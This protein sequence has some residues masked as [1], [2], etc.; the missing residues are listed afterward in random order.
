MAENRI[1]PTAHDPEVGR[2]D[3]CRVHVFAK[4]NHYGGVGRNASRAVDAVCEND[5]RRCCVRH[6]VH[7][8]RVTSGVSSTVGRCDGNRVNSS[9]KWYRISIP[10]HVNLDQAAWEEIADPDTPLVA[11]RQVIW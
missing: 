11:L 1:I 6:P 9:D 10:D 7:L 3:G 8:N 4:R 5:C 2:V